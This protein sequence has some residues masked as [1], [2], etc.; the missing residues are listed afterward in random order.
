MKIKP[1]ILGK[2]GLLKKESKITWLKSEWFK[3]ELRHSHFCFHTVTNSTTLYNA[4]LWEACGQ[5]QSTCWCG[6]CWT[7]C[8]GLGAP[9]HHIPSCPRFLPADSTVVRLREKPIHS[10]RRSGTRDRI[11][12]IPVPLSSWNSNANLRAAATESSVIK[13]IKR[14]LYCDYASCQNVSWNRKWKQPLCSTYRSLFFNIARSYFMPKTWYRTRLLL[15][16]QPTF[17]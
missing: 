10:G 15:A 1:S 6:H 13:R 9:T 11:H 4:D 3:L 16:L 5:N 2:S 12:V 14:H 7:W 8:S 17:S